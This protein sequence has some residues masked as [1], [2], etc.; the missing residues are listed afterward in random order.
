MQEVK[1]YRQYA[2]DCRH[3]A[4]QMKQDVDKQRL[5]EMAAA[6]DARAEEAER[7]QRKRMDGDNQRLGSKSESPG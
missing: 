5:L 2:T 7:Q 6:W 4:G 3:M 1:K